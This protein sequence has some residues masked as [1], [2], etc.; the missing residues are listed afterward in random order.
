MNVRLRVAD[1]IGAFALALSS[2]AAF[3][4][5][6]VCGPIT[7]ST[8][9]L[10][11]SSPYR[12]TCDVTV[13][14]N[15]TL[16][17]EPGVIVKFNSSRRLIVNGTLV[18]GG[19]A[20]DEVV[21]TSYRDDSYGG[22]TNGDGASSGNPGDWG[23]I[24][25]SAP[26]AG[27]QMSYSR[28][29]FA[30]SGATPTYGI[31]LNTSG[32]LSLANC[33]V[34]KTANPQ[35]SYAVF[36]GSGTTL[37]MTDCLVQNNLGYG[38]Y[39]DG[40]WA[41][42]SNAISGNQYGLLASGGG[43]TFSGN[44]ITANTL[45]G[46]QLHP[47]MVSGVWLSNTVQGNGYLNSL[48]VLSGTL[49]NSVTWVDEYQYRFLGD[50][51][52]PDLVTLSLE[53][54]AILKFNSSRR[55]IVNG[56]LVSNGIAGDEVVFTSYRD[57]NFGGDTNGDGAS[58]GSPGD[59][60]RIDFSA[61]DAGCQMSYSRVRFA[62]GLTNPSQGI[63]LVTSGTLALAN[64]VVEKT[65]NPQNSYAVFA[66]S[67]TTLQMT[68]CVVQNNLGYG[69]YNTGA[70]V[71]NNVGLT[72]N[73]SYG[74]YLG[75]TSQSVDQASIAG[76]GGGVYCA[77][78]P[79]VLT[80]TSISGCSGP[81]VNTLPNLVGE[82]I[83]N[84][85][86][87]N[88][89]YLNAIWVRGGN[90]AADD[91]WPSAF[92]YVIAGDIVVNA[93]VTLTLESGALAKVNGAYRLEVKGTLVAVGTGIDKV[94]FTSFKDDTYGGDTNQDQ[95][96]TSPAKGDWRGLYLNGASSGTTLRWVIVKYGG[97]ND[98]AALDIAA[99]NII[100][101][102][103]I[104][105]TNKGNGISVGATSTLS[106]SHSD[107][108]A[109]G[110]GVGTDYGLYNGRA[111][112]TVLAENCYWGDAS[113]PAPTG[114]GNRAG[115]AGPV[116]YTPWL[117]RSI[118][119]PWT[120]VGSPSSSGNFT[121]VEIF[122]LN[123]DSYLDA[124]A[125]TLGNGLRVFRRDG[126]DTWSAV[127]SPITAGDVRSVRRCD[128]NEDS[129]EDLIVAGAAGIQY[130]VGDGAG[131]LTLGTP[132]VSSSSILDAVVGL[133]DHDGHED[134]VGCS[135]NNQGIYVVS[136]LGTGSWGV[137]TRPTTTGSFS[138][139]RLADV[140]QNGYQ[141][142]VATSTEGLGVRVWLQSASGLWTAG[143]P[144]GTGTS[145]YAL[146][147]G[148]V[149]RDGDYDLAVGANQN[150]IGIR[151]YLNDGTGSWT[152]GNSPT[153]FGI[154]NDVVLDDLNG[155][156]RLDM[157]AAS[158]GGGIRVWTGTS[159]QQWNYWYDPATANIFASIRVTDFT[160]NGS[161]DVAAAS[162]NNQGIALWDNQLPGSFQEYFSMTPTSLAFGQV[163]VGACAHRDLQLTNVSPDTVRSVVVYGSSP[164]I[165]VSFPS[166][167]AGPF[168]LA[169]GQS[170]QVQ[171]SYCPTNQGAD[172]EAVVVHSTVAVAY[173]RSAGEGVPYIAP[174]WA[175][176][177]NVRN[178][179]G[180][181]G[182][183]QNVQVGGGVGA[184][185]G[186]DVAAGEVCLPPWP[187]S[188][189]FDAR[190]TIDGCEGSIVSIHDVYAESDTFNVTWQAGAGGYP[191]T[192]S[193]SPSSIPEGTFILTDLFGGAYLG[194]IDMSEQGQLVIPANLSF[195]EG[196]EIQA[197]RFSTF[198]HAY[199][200]GWQLTSVPV[201]GDSDLLSALF[202]GAIS[203]WAWQ[204][205]YQQVTHLSNCQGYW[206]NMPA[207]GTASQLGWKVR[208]CSEYLP[209]SW[210]LVGAVWDTVMVTAIQQVP[211]G[212]IRSVFGYS[213]GYQTTD[214]LI[215]GRGY[216]FDLSQPCQLTI[217]T[218][219]RPGGRSSGASA[220]DSRVSSNAGSAT[221]LSKSD[222]AWRFPM[223]VG[224]AGAHD[225]WR[226]LECALSQAASDSIDWS[227]GEVELPPWQPSSV[228]EARF[229]VEG[230]NG[231]Y[232]DFRDPMKPQVY[233]H[234]VWQPGDQGFPISI[235][236]DPKN[237]PA[238][239]N[240]IITDDLDGTILGPIDCRATDGFQIGEDLS[241]L[242]G[243]R[244]AAT[245]SPG[246]VDVLMPSPVSAK[247]ELLP[248][249]PNPSYGRTTLR[250]SLP[251]SGTAALEIFDISGRRVRTLAE[252]RYEAGMQTVVW[253]DCD[254]K[255]HPVRSGVYYVRLVSN[256]GTRTRAIHITR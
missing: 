6:D 130:L 254:G 106:V 48:G 152:L 45:F 113:G 80:H 44:Q 203:A 93:G 67:G 231:T 187:P 172:N 110:D 232:A 228:F 164:E 161:K 85:V 131:G 22:D 230:S 42:Q 149:D 119:N 193:W 179:V 225:E 223:E 8:T 210:S 38:V 204:G 197:R 53:A 27:C 147:V 226:K 24:D 253:D 250:F 190:C 77:T 72:G 196:V 76:C 244:I 218:S 247:L 202:P 33:V 102:E 52:V 138:R 249:M 28:V 169:P 188:S 216:W 205:G 233:W 109:N 222:A 10:K 37:Q 128:V 220:G 29:R 182:N 59:W 116:D 239:V 66:G 238:G 194:T 200:K 191:V 12:V 114:S 201:I 83:A 180:G 122:D 140:D 160:I 41:L 69:V 215:P 50:V 58:T 20:G 89:A 181:S 214:R 16:T 75:G 175:V 36:A 84:C 94:I 26:D 61:P 87:T 207:A 21:F 132:V 224:V 35:N 70:L 173:A 208:Q 88:N 256:V 62:G 198:P 229:D 15:V 142:I 95:D 166:L 148:D 73:G 111:S 246:A 209:A 11:A 139:V 105:T 127:A 31:N 79:A 162:M 63:N 34:E 217:G 1:L 5:T 211:P 104:V 112:A 158:Q 92:S 156:H 126:F 49:G 19:I 9:W 64:C 39:I 235:G 255:G 43:T 153:S 82:F 124:A 107:I 117:D 55:L 30:G 154:F 18:S 101:Q 100:A 125:G 129:D 143:T 137:S 81:A 227:L 86:I 195:I 99:T 212:S 151:I 178:Q 74:L 141:D 252:R 51:T 46:C 243:V 3:G 241:Y 183:N 248:P 68:D 121:A 25:F 199:S 71:A 103:L 170:K 120:S 56:T 134:V 136:G 174:V 90:V 96:T 240:L 184:T 189:V 2:T 242:T 245:I 155:D 144:A 234:L 221:G 159:S 163:M 176:T 47:V 186:L 7:A 54:G 32:T 91:F 60:G 65:A 213:N 14:D 171:V 97:N 168:D 40:A 237:L 165:Q 236:W 57:D 13:Q 150:G 108:Y 98:V 185:R 157:V 135:G 167:D 23:R 177:V 146:D 123:S 118:D 4:T 17:I 219:P 133:V 115:G 145:F 192:L 206:L 251:S 78:E